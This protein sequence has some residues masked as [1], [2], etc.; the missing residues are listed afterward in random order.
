[1]TE[2]WKDVEGF[3][4]YMISN[5]GRLY[6]KTHV[7]VFEDGR[8]RK[9]E[10]QFIKIYKSKNGYSIARLSHK[11][12]KKTKYIHRL[13]A[14][15]F[16]EKNSGKNEINHKDG[17]K[18]NNKIENLEWCTSKE[19][20]VHGWQNKLYKPHN[21]MRGTKHGNCKMSEKQVLEIRK[22][23]DEKKKTLKELSLLFN[24]PHSTIQKIVYRKTWKNLEEDI[25]GK[26]LR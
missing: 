23:Y 1:M 22:L 10:G 26:F 13:V 17:N 9:F 6:S 12:V 24:A 16:I 14:N 19:N 15:H 25:N 20:K 2:E 11:G 7:T 21:N 8:R 5:C 18:S 3:P 4:N